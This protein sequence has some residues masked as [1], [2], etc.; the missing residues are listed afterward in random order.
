MIWIQIMSFF[1]LE[2]WKSF[3]ITS[4][5]LSNAKHQWHVCYH[6]LSFIVYNFFDPHTRPDL[7]FQGL[8][9]E[10]WWG[11]LSFIILFINYD[12]SQ[13]AIC[14]YVFLWNTNG[15]KI[16]ITYF[17]FIAMNIYVFI[18]INICSPIYFLCIPI[19]S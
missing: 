4:L 9:I 18:C 10:S 1:C 7:T 13:N 8:N 16:K 2:W 19:M 17:H 5:V 6:P 15:Y 14:P 11:P 12:S 3:S